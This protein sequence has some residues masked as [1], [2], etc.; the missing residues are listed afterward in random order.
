[1]LG[2]FGLSLVPLELKAI[3]RD[4]LFA[5]ERAQLR[6]DRELPLLVACCLEFNDRL[7]AI[8]HCDEQLIVDD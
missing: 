4:A 6:F 7:L 2:D 1:M 3:G 8:V 5:G